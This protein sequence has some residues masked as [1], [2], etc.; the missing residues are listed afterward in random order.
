MKKSVLFLSFL[1]CFFLSKS[2]LPFWEWSIKATPTV[3]DQIT[4]KICTDKFGNIYVLGRNN[5]TYWL[6]NY[7]NDQPDSTSFVAKYSTQG[8][9]LWRIFVKGFPEC[10]GTDDY[11]SIYVAGSFTG[12]IPG[13]S[14]TLSSD[15]GSDIFVSKYTSS[16]SLLW[17]KKFGGPKNQEVYDM[18]VTKT[19]NVYITGSFDE[20]INFGNAILYNDQQYYLA[21]LNSSGSV[22]WSKPAPVTSDT[23]YVHQ[24]GYTIR[25]DKLE[26]VYVLCETFYKHCEFYCNGSALVKYDHNGNQLG[27][28]PK[29]GALDRP[30]QLSIDHN[31]NIFIVY[32]TGSH[33]D[34]SCDLAKFDQNMNLLWSKYLG[35]PGYAGYGFRSGMVLDSNNDPYVLGILGVEQ[36]IGDTLYLENQTLVRKGYIDVLVA[37]LD[38]SN[39]NILKCYVGGTK[40]WDYP[41]GI[42]IDRA[43]NCFVTG[44]F[45]YYPQNSTKYDPFCFDE[46]CVSG[47]G[48]YPQG[49]ISKLKIS[50]QEFQ[51]DVQITELT[52][53]S[54]FKLYPN[55][56]RGKFLIDPPGPDANV[57]IYNT[58]GTCIYDQAL[59]EKM[60]IDLSDYPKGIYYVEAKCAD[61]RYNSKLVIE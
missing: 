20:A 35:T 55:P 33:Y 13:T 38:G 52:T 8:Q 31:F 24:Q 56:S 54:G 25:F 39:G 42:C 11:G 17:V 60:E 19:G 28:F 57:Y 51:N 22:L 18:G 40:N 3:T 37:K 6:P 26:N 30:F 49:F 48:N 47:T 5:V 14:S 44:T 9:L 2:Q 61:H 45:Y 50:D 58:T 23:N 46:A 16:G 41:S 1:I 15:D 32:H 43:G 4:S 7:H 27:Y 36:M 12:T 34:S 21:K 59:T 10:I 29:W 53:T